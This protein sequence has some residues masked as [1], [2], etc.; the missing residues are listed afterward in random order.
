LEVSHL[1]ANALF[2]NQLHFLENNELDDFNDVDKDE[3]NEESLPL[4]DDNEDD[5]DEE[6]NEQSL[7]IHDEA[8]E[9]T[10]L[11]STDDA[12]GT[13]MMSGSASVNDVKNCANAEDDAD[14]EEGNEHTL[15]IHDDA[16]EV[17]TLPSTEEAAGPRMTS[18]S[19]SSD[20][21]L[22]CT[23]PKCARL[24]L[25]DYLC[26][27]CGQPVHWFCAAGHPAG[28]EKGHGSH[29][30]CP[31]CNLQK[32]NTS[33]ALLVSNSKPRRACNK[34]VA[35]SKQ[36]K[37]NKKSAKNVGAVTPGSTSKPWR[38]PKKAVSAIPVDDYTTL[39][40]LPP[41][42]GDCVTL[43]LLPP[44]I[45]NSMIETDTVCPSAQKFLPPSTG[46]SSKPSAKGRGRKSCARGAVLGSG[47]S[48]EFIGK[49]VAFF[50][51]SP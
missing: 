51:G 28:N 19:A 18:G 48:N 22:P 24:M 12:A 41:D 14:D 26:I 36:C 43:P 4:Y 11:Q 37:G 46:S 45:A 6:E 33:S 10:I 25:K 23:I 17:T 38:V 9:V 40:P 35:T 44:N 7:L 49:L 39:P 21:L 47:Q 5:H 1:L 13:R 27:G 34:P 32:S 42:M 29:Y 8:Q 30:W 15:P 2:E 16:Q 50:L 3:E 31:P 20:D